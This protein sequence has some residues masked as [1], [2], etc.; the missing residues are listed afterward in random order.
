MPYVNGIDFVEV[1]K[2]IGC[3]CRHIA[4]M[5]GDWQDCY[6]QKASVLGVHIFSKPFHVQQF[7]HWLESVTDED[8]RLI[9][10]CAEHEPSRLLHAS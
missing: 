2:R 10:S 5:S 4:M 8:V 9:G 7:E 1:L 3:K 6:L